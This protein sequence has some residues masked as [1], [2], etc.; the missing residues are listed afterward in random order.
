MN[1]DLIEIKD[2]NG[3]KQSIDRYELAQAF[4]GCITKPLEYLKSSIFFRAFRLFVQEKA[5]F[6]SI[7]FQTRMT[8]EFVE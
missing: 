8:I 1:N 2:L 7:D 4:D 3:R 5:S 6:L